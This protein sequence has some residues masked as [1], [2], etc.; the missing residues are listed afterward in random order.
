M[1]SLLFRTCHTELIVEFRSQR[2]RE[3]ENN[4]NENE[5]GYQNRPA[6][7][8]VGTSEDN[9]VLKLGFPN[10]R[11]RAFEHVCRSGDPFINTKGGTSEDTGIVKDEDDYEGGPANQ[12]CDYR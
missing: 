3:Q 4:H 7:N 11:L 5:G 8:P 10:A 2:G 12:V 1:Y 9:A 6:E